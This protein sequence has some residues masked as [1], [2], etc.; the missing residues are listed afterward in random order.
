MLKN[1]RESVTDT[2]KVSD[3]YQNILASECVCFSLLSYTQQVHGSA[4]SRVTLESFLNGVLVLQSFIDLEINIC[5]LTNL[6]DYM[7]VM[8]RFLCHLF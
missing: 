5:S 3:F 1:L 6:Q 7:E 2:F 4:T 8:I